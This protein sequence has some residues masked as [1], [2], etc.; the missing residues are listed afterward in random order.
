MI[1]QMQGKF[2]LTVMAGVGHMVQEVSR[3]L[4][5]HQYLRVKRFGVICR[6]IRHTLQISFSN[7]GG[8]MS[9]SHLA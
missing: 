7:F 9:T 8:G 3:H 5:C 2:Q 1:G 6:M 4:Q